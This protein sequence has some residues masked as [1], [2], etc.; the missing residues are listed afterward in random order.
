MERYLNGLMN[1]KKRSRKNVKVAYVRGRGR[2]AFAARNF[3]PGDFVCEYPSVVREKEEPDRTEESNAEIGVGCYCLDAIYKGK[4]Y[5]FDASP[6]C[7]DPGRYINHAAKNPN[8][9]LK[10]PLMVGKPP[11]KRLRIGFVAK[12]AI[13]KGHELFFDYGIKDKD[14]PWLTTDA[15][16]VAITLDQGIDMPYQLTTM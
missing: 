5:T 6:K 2:S 7:N 9:I 12:S 10:Q 1:A 14:L 16:K 4:M 8:L 13:K 11:N 15:K 3:T